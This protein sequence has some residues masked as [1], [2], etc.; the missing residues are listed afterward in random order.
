[1]PVTQEPLF[2]QYSMSLMTYPHIR[3]RIILGLQSATDGLQSVIGLEITKYNRAGLQITIR[4]GLQSM[5]KILKIGLQRTMGL[6]SADFTLRILHNVRS[7]FNEE[8]MP[9]LFHLTVLNNCS[10]FA[11]LSKHNLGN[12]G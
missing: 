7:S 9:A 8:T 2:I 1:M 5:T 10:N 4:F 11:L 6:Q 12:F 3:A